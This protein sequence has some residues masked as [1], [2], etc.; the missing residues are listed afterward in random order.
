MTRPSGSFPASRR[1]TGGILLT[2]GIAAAVPGLII[3][4]VE[5]WHGVANRH[6]PIWQNIAGAAL[7]VAAG[8]SLIQTGS[9]RETIGII[10]AAI[11]LFQSQQPGGQRRTDP[12][13]EDDNPTT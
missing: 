12:P 9:A 13:A 8:A 10:K 11:P 3:A 4:F 5:L 7:F 2:L 6:P 1:I